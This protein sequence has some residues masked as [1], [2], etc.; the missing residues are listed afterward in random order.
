MA[1]ALQGQQNQVGNEFYGL[2][3][4]H[5][6]NSSTF[7]GIYDLEGAQTWLREIE[8]I[9]HVMVCTEEHK[10]LFDTRM[11]LEEAEDWWDNTRQRLN[12]VCAKITWTRDAHH[13]C[14]EG[15]IGLST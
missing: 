11:L 3:K 8:K 9:F 4:F 14:L 15:Q 13:T 1:Q 7:K 5:R 2:G 10:V 6:N 12:V